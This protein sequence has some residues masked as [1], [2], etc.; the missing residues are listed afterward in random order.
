MHDYYIYDALTLNLVSTFALANTVWMKVNHTF[1]CCSCYSFICFRD[2][3]IP[4]KSKNQNPH[5]LEQE[6]KRRI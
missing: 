3:Q 5:I 4:K 2:S 6:S 1:Y